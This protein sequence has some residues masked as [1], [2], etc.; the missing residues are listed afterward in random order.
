MSITMRV[1]ACWPA[2]TD[3]VEAAVDAQGDAS[4]LVDA[5][6]AD[7]PVDI[8]AA[9]AGAGFGAGGVSGR[10]RDPSGQGAVR[11][12]AV[13]DVDEHVA[14]G[15][16]FVDGGGLVGL[17]PQPVLERLLEPFDLAAGGRMVRTAVLLG[18]PEPAQFGLEAVAAA[19]AAGEPGGE[20]HPVVGQRRGGRPV[21]GDGGAEGVDHDGARDPAVGGDGQGVAGV[22]IQPGQDLG[23]GAGAQRVVGEVGLPHLVGLVGLEPDITRPRPFGGSGS[24]QALAAQRAVDGRPRHAQV[25]IVLEVPADRVRTRVQTLGDQLPAQFDD[26]RDRALVDSGG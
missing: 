18:D 23:V 17:G 16:E 10:G 11:A 20:H 3:V 12:S 6:G 14:Q 4:G 25:V 22:V 13:V 19:A 5:V 26:Q 1:R 9:V 21:L 8:A 2:E 24:D 15:L 7:A